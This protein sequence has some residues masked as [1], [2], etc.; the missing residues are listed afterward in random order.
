MAT[1]QNQFS[2]F[3]GSYRFTDPVRYF[4]STD[5]YYWEIDNIP[6]KQLQ[7]NDLWLKDQI[8]QG[9]KNFSVT[10]DRKDFNELKPFSD[11]LN[12]IVKVNPGKFS[13][14]VN[15]VETD[16]RLM[17]ITRILGRVFDDVNA[18]RFATLAD[19][20]VFGH[21]NQITSDVGV[22]S[23]GMNGLVERVYTWTVRNPFQIFNDFNNAA[24]FTS[25]GPI[26]K[27][28]Y[29]GGITWNPGNIPI[30]QDQSYTPAGRAAGMNRM[31]NIESYFMKFWR[32]V[33]RLAIVNVPEVLDFQIPAFDEADFN[34]IDENGVTQTQPGVEVRIDLLFIYAK[35]VDAPRTKVR[36]SSL[37]NSRVLTTPQLGLVRG[38]G[39]VMLKNNNNSGANTLDS[40]TLDSAGNLK[41][42]ASPADANSST[43]GFTDL[44]IKGSFPAPD[45]LINAAPLI[46]ESLQEDDPRLIGQT[47]LPIAYIVVKKDAVTNEFGEVIITNDDI[48]DIRPFFRTAEL[49]YNER[50]GLG[51]AMPQTSISNPVVT[52]ARLKNM[53]FDIGQEIQ[54]TESRV[55]SAI[56]TAILRR[57]RVVGAG[58][59][60]GGS[61]Y[62]PEGAIRNYYENGGLDQTQ[63]Y[64]R[65]RE[66]YNFAS[67]Q[68]T[69]WLPDWD[70]APWVPNTDRKR[71]PNDCVH[72]HAHPFTDI[73]RDNEIFEY[74]GKCD[75]T[76]NGGKLEQMI[77]PSL[78]FYCKKTIR[79]DRTAVDWM[80]H[81]TV[82]AHLVNCVPLSHAVQY[83]NAN[84]TT[85]F[86]GASDI[87]IEY[88]YDQFT[89]Y[90]AWVGGQQNIQDDDRA[91]DNLLSQNAFSSSFEWNNAFRNPN[92]GYGY[93]RIERTKT[94]KY[95]Q[96]LNTG[97][98]TLRDDPFVAA[99]FTVMNR[100]LSVPTTRNLQTAGICIYPTVKFT[101]EGFPANWAGY[102][103][104]MSNEN[105][106]VRLV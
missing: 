52:E 83:K 81:Y 73:G 105:A 49:T 2:F 37:A 63:S 14:R 26:Q 4:T 85:N 102:A 97:L 31:A 84:Y 92:T 91:Q 15:Y 61:K 74:I 65:L 58:T 41:I 48:I 32:G 96:I 88:G 82:N 3:E 104:N 22:S 101:I 47:G 86:A 78:I 11:G 54:V 89:I 13:A 23:L 80:D 55:R 103:E 21:V 27:L 72:I 28:Y 43:G 34:Y 87:W 70:V 95:A 51:A 69:P 1:S 40:A 24:G 9:F 17:D 29:W 46:L 68:S 18:W 33:F 8:E 53:A 30:G 36:G 106:N 59:I 71:Y 99:G 93:S 100:E 77:N 12:N 62:G 90:C 60:F 75:L 79:I 6:L 5:P 39:V 64:Q 98:E 45:D 19:S 38:A 42:L 25:Y 16:S 7:E 66:R 57:A 20:E 67:Q 35:P 56:D 50:A 94:T 76:Y 44:N 10:F